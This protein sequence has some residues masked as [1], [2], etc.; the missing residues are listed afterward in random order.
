MH[1]PSE[2]SVWRTMFAFRVQSF[3]QRK[4]F[5]NLE[6]PSDHYKEKSMPVHLCASDGKRDKCVTRC[7][8][9]TAVSGECFRTL[10]M[11]YKITQVN[12]FVLRFSCFKTY[13]KEKKKYT[14]H[15]DFISGLFLIFF[16][17]FLARILSFWI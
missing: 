8:P 7:W 12:I 2:A 1:I 15:L 16:S 10:L 14:E 6:H 11:T 13:F 5:V 17:F 4:V 3:T 9:S